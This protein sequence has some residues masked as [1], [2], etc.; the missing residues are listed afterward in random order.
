MTQT[1]RM[2]K[3]QI[4]YSRRTKIQLSGEKVVINILWLLTLYREL[5][6]GYK[7]RRIPLLFTCD[8]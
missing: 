4:E 5:R 1:T 7:F 6:K 2:D 3:K 8:V